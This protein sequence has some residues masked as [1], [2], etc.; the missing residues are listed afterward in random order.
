MHKLSKSVLTMTLALTGAAVLWIE[1]SRAQAPA[2]AQ[3]PGAQAQ[4]G[5]GPAGQAPGAPGGA[6]RGGG[7]RGAAAVPGGRGGP[8]AAPKKHLLVIGMTRGYH[9]GSTSRR[10]GDVLES[11]EGVRRV[12]HRDQDRHGVGQQE[13][14]RER[15]PQPAVLRCH[16]VCELHRRLEAGRRAEGGAAFLRQGRRQGA[17]RGA[18][19][20]GCQLRLAGVRRDDRR[21]VPC[22]PLGHLR[23]AGHC[24][25]PDV[26]GDAALPQIP[27]AVR[28]DVLRRS[29]G[30]A[31][32]STC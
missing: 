31:T 30:R 25:G 14:P 19:L 15:S 21:L 23:R 5:R 6:A 22:S 2:P 9:H 12:G 3:T 27:Q 1:T 16:G 10:R 4:P 8:A 32:R 26:P 20:S 13:K 11:R 28:R 24:R 18:C 29:S 17:R 7:G